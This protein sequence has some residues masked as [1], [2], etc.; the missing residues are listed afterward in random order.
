MKQQEPWIERNKAY[1][2]EYQKTWR[3]AF[4]A[5]HGCSYETARQRAKKLKEQEQETEA[6]KGKSL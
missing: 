6:T 4:K 3:A 5:K 1:R 2:R